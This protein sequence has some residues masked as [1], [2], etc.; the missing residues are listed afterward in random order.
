M[1]Q[2]IAFIASVIVLGAYALLQ[3]GKL[4][5]EGRLFNFMNFVA[6]GALAL[7][8][9]LEHQWGFLFLEGTWSVVSMYAL[10]KYWS[11][12]IWV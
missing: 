1:N 4:S 2:A 8:A 3:T 11:K 10:I 6:T 12:K 9:W 5:N 7:I